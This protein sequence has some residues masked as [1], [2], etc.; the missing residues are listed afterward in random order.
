M[1]GS[2]I[3]ISAGSGNWLAFLVGEDTPLRESIDLVHALFEEPRIRVL[4]TSNN[5]GGGESER[6]IGLAIREYGGVPDDFL[7]V[8]KA[9]RDSA[10][11]E[12]SGVRMRRSLE[13]SRER[14]GLERFPLLYLH[15]PENTTWES[16]M[17]DDGP[18]AALVEARDAGLIGVLGVAGGPAALMQRYVETG[19]FDALI[20]HNRYT[21]V[22]RSADTL[23]TVAADRGLHVTNAAPYGGGLLTAWPPPLERYAYAPVSEGIRSSAE[24][25][26]DI[27]RRH[28]VPLA[29][30]AL[31]FSLRDPRIDRTIVGMRTIGDLAATI[32]LAETPVPAAVWAELESVPLATADW[33][34]PR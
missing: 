23:L 2:P 27:C 32:E 13:E 21:L 11:G 34:D 9:D 26:A 18:V 10:T 6:R 17:A 3:P 7:I 1:T 25:V 8:T 28:D 22:D 16:A 14:M 19:L 4:D 5:Y 24:R 30:A 29:A 20:T 15:D 33:R 31:N 12:F